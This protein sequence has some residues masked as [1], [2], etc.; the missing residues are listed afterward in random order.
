M[1]RA[2]ERAK[3]QAG[4]GWLSTLVGVLVLVAGGFVI[5]LIVGVV[6]EEPE[7]V[8]GHVAGRSTEIDW[9]ASK[10]APLGVQEDEEA[11]AWFATGPA[12][13]PELNRAVPVVAAPPPAIRKVV[14]SEPIYLIQVG[15]FADGVTARGLADRLKMGGYPVLVAEP[16][17]DDRWRVRVGP[18]AR[19]EADELAAQLKTEERLPTWILRDAGS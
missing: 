2:E 8:A 15:A 13:E 12:T 4:Q 14:H 16:D 5:G 6:S 17:R 18:V 10:S 9:T 11:P 1:S 3:R 7:L 19:A